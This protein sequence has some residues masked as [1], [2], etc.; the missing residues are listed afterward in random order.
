[1]EKYESKQQQILL[2]AQ[3]RKKSQLKICQQSQLNVAV[4]DLER[5]RFLRWQKLQR[6]YLKMHQKQLNQLNNQ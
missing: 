4:A 2:Q 5:I 6:L 3:L 1:M